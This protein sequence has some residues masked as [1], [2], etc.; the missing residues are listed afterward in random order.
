MVDWYFYL[1]QAL[2]N[3]QNK[4][5]PNW[6]LKDGVELESCIFGQY[7]CWT[8]AVPWLTSPGCGATVMIA[9]IF[10]ECSVRWQHWYYWQQTISWSPVSGLLDIS[11]QDNTRSSV[12]KDIQYFSSLPAAAHLLLLDEYLAPSTEYGALS[13]WTNI[14]LSDQLVV[15]KIRGNCI[16]LVRCFRVC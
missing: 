9:G 7:V 12:F 2:W 4:N 11:P 15:R 8:R 5:K 13:G 16:G 14:A 3:P 1:A 6:L 10:T